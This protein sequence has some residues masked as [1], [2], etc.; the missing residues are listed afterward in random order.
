MCAG[1]EEV[2]GLLENVGTAAASHHGAAE[3]GTEARFPDPPMLMLGK[4]VLVFICIFT[5]GPLSH[6]LAIYRYLMCSMA[7]P[8]CNIPV[9]APE[10][11]SR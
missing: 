6:L 9:W 1:K 5:V 4:L 7:S 2:S 8:L 3:L 11:R 10:L